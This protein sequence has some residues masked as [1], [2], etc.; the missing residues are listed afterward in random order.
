[1]QKELVTLRYGAYKKQQPMN[2]GHAEELVTLRYG[3]YKRCSMNLGRAK[4]LLT[5]RYGA[6]K[7]KY[8][9]KPYESRTCRR[10]SNT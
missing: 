1:M 7:K 9:K 2:L 6:Y 8:I 3:A 10:V 5:I 4:K